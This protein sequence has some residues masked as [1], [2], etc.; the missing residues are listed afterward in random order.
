MEA[1]KLLCCTEVKKRDVRD[2]TTELISTGRVR[3]KRYT[4]FY[5]HLI[6]YM[7]HPAFG[8]NVSLLDRSSK[9]RYFA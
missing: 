8:G 9:E 4:V 1:N 7:Y 6:L 2:M 3:M 5:E